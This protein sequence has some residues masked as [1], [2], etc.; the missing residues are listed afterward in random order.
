MGVGKKNI[1][2][3]GEEEVHGGHGV[4]R[5]K[6]QRGDRLPG[7]GTGRDYKLGMRSEEL[8]M[9]KCR[10]RFRLFTKLAAA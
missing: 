2:H 9:S 6:A 4:L 7:G 10:V 5:G 1:Y 8:G 3:G